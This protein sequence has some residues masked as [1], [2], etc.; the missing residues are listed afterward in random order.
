M[1]MNN[2]RISNFLFSKIPLGD[3]AAI[4]VVLLLGGCT[5]TGVG[6]EDDGILE[7]VVEQVASTGS[8]LFY[9][10]SSGNG[11]MSRLDSAGDYTFVR[12]VPGFATGWTHIA[13]T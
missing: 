5:D 12:G 9:N 6:S 1:H 7:S 4:S 8:W 10:T 13:G 3:F 11:A 2:V